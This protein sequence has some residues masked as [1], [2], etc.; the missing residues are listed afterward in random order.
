MSDG[1]CVFAA[2]SVS[3]MTYQRMNTKAEST[4]LLLFI[5]FVRKKVAIQ[6]DVGVLLQD[7]ISVKDV[8]DV[9]EEVYVVQ[10]AGAGERIEDDT[11]FCAFVTA[12]E[13]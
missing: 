9:I 1:D 4:I 12:E 13:Q 8:A 10:S 7:S 5:P 11:A 3:A 6:T 2:V